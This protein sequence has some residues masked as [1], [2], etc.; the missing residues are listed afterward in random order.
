MAHFQVYQPI[1]KDF[2]G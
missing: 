1:P 2:Q